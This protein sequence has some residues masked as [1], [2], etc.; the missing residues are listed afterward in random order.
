MASV[1]ARR[2]DFSARLSSISESSVADAE[3][4]GVRR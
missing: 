1:V 3:W 4:T 2:Q